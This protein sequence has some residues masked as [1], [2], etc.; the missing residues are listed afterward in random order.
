MPG[1]GELIVIL[2]IVLVVFGA[3]KLP[4][5]GDALGRSIRN[6]KKASNVEGEEDDKIDDK[7][8][9]KKELASAK[10]SKQLDEGDG[11]EG[12]WEEVVVRR[13]KKPASATGE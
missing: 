5:I 10:A 12:E 9:K 1:M 2:L 8:G 11:D 13:R 7:A 6:F 4:G 3:N